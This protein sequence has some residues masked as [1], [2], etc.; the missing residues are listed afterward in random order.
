M[1][2]KDQKEDWDNAIGLPFGSLMT[3]LPLQCGTRWGEKPYT[4]VRR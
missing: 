3:I 1:N 2:R 4:H